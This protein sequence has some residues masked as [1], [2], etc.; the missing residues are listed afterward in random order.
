MAQFQY[1][2]KQG[3]LATIEA[4]DANAAIAASRP[5]ADPHSGVST[6]SNS[7]SAANS[8][9]LSGLQAQ[10]AELQKNTGLSSGAQ[11]IYQSQAPA[12]PSNNFISDSTTA[13]TSEKTTQAVVNALN[14]A[15]NS[16]GLQAARDASAAIQKSLEDYSKALEERR[17]REV[18]AIEK[19]FAEARVGTQDAQKRETATTN[20]ALFRVGGY[21]GTQISGVG[22]LNNLSQ[23]HT[24]ELN[25]LEAKKA[26]AINAANTAVEDKQFQLAKAR[27]EEARTL[28]NEIEQRRN[29]FFNQLMTV[30]NQQQE[31]E[32]LQLTIANQE[33]DDARTLISGIVNT[34]GGASFD[35]LDPASQSALADM[36]VKAGY[37]IDLIRGQFETLK[38]QKMAQQQENTMFQQNIAL[39][40][41]AIRQ[42]SQAL[43]ERRF[44]YTV[45]Q[46]GGGGGGGGG[47]SNSGVPGYNKN[48]GLAY[49]QWYPKYLATEDG[50]KFAGQF[51]GDN[52]GLAQALRLLYKSG[53]AT[54][55]SKLYPSSKPDSNSGGQYGRYNL[56]TPVK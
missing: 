9:S 21:L 7:S 19:Q 40:N 29:N 12:V 54:Q 6:V 26:A 8:G 42:A 41:L 31:D 25:A 44:Q 38:E 18:E 16:P 48:V 46:D 23:Q 20:T 24:I 30:V 33:R 27:A 28:E 39:A 53:T 32:K 4:A 55:L 5:Y 22:V 10:I 3:Q 36:A 43:S 35:E 56:P 17:K 52:I 34:F 15:Q 45:S 50:K 49:E 13:I 37:P 2:N 1:V 47:G 14:A 11:K 51:A